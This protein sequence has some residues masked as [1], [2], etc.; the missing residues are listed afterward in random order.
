MS[1]TLQID[2]V[3]FE[4]REK[5]DFRWLQGMGKVF[6]VFDRQHS[7]NLCFGVETSSGKVFVKY[8]GAK[9][10]E[11]KGEPQGAVSRLRQAVT[12]Y[13]EL[14]HPVLA[15]LLRTSE[16]PE[17]FAA[18]FEWCEGECLMPETGI[19]P[20]EQKADWKSPYRRFRQLPIYKRLDAFDALLSFHVH[21]E[22][23]GFVAIDFHD[24]NIL[25][26][27]ATGE[28]KICDI[29]FYMKKPFINTVGTLWGSSR[30]MSPEEF[31]MGASI[32]ERTNVFNMGAIAFGLLG[33]EKDRALSLWEAGQL[34]YD[35][36]ARAVDRDKSKR[37]TSVADFATEW[38]NRRSVQA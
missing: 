21:V 24:G 37:Y 1:C 32:D 4:L 5:H 11:Y 29:D 26:D 8:A 31:E 30:F 15:R 16:T 22:A 33:G 34:L 18:V 17:G 36:A 7:G 25:Y 28:I 14:R 13:R 6:I 19:P 38:A 3:S 10:I 35:V 9:T 20:A 27:F 23:K 2:G 12:V